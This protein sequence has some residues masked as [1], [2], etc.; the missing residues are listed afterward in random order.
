MQAHGRQQHAA[1]H[2]NQQQHRLRHDPRPVIAAHVRAEGDDAQQ[3]KRGG[4]AILRPFPENDGADDE[5][6]DLEKEPQDA[7][8]PAS[9]AAAGRCGTTRPVLPSFRALDSTRMTLGHSTIRWGSCRPGRGPAVVPSV[10]FSCRRSASLCRNWPVGDADRRAERSYRLPEEAVGPEIEKLG[11]EM[12]D[13]RRENTA[14]ADLRRQHHVTDNPH[15]ISADEE[16][17]HDDRQSAASDPL[18]KECQNQG[19][20]A[21]S[22]RS[23]PP[24]KGR[25]DQGSQCHLAHH[26]PCCSESNDLRLKAYATARFQSPIRENLR[27]V[28]FPHFIHPE[29]GGQSS[30]RCSFTK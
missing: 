12:I 22:Q 10:P 28:F 9:P 14:N 27:S 2:E 29:M 20:K 23:D 11:V 15:G 1:N 24:P 16:G 8:A 4:G 13:D 25:S 26:R 5:Q 30:N 17:G 6:A 7:T 3:E 21:N 19:R 18:P